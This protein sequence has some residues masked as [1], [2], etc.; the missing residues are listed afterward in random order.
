[1][2]LNQRVHFIGIGGAGLSAIAT[3]L[4][5]RGH[6]VSGSD[7]SESEANLRGNLNGKWRNQLK[8]AETHN[9]KINIGS[10]A[11]LFNWLMKQ[12]KTM[13]I[14]KSFI[15][16]KA[17]LYE[18][19]FKQNPNKLIIFQAC[20]DDNPVAGQMY[21]IHGKTSTYLVG[22]SS[23]QGRKKHAHN[24]LIWNPHHKYF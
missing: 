10:S 23:D 4:H 15:G 12:Y 21:I 16:P 11:S 17:G 18:S 5:E 3:V 9:M 20:Y 6:V 7:L 8:K 22:W 19:I 24:F 1:M 13:Q 2:L 14:D